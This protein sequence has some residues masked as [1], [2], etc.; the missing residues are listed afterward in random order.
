MSTDKAVTLDIDGAKYGSAHSA[1][2]RIAHSPGGMML[3]EFD[4]PRQ[5]F[6][7]DAD[8]A[9]VEA[10]G[11]SVWDAR[12]KAAGK[13]QVIVSVTARGDVADAKVESSNPA[14]AFTDAD[15]HAFFENRKYAPLIESGKAAPARIRTTLRFSPPVPDSTAQEQASVP[16]PTAESWQLNPPRYPPGLAKQGI[17]GT[18]VLIVDVAANGRP[19][20]VKVD[21]AEPAGVFDAAAIEAA[22]KWTFQPQLKNGKPVPGRVRVPIQFAPDDEAAREPWPAPPSIEG[23]KGSRQ[24]S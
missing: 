21:R 3:D 2:V 6:P 19:T 15:A 7:R 10:D 4:S 18:V 11:G 16:K 8:G 9:Y 12:F 22:Y 17:G 24:A 23:V 1:V 20:A 14:G 13:A 5:R